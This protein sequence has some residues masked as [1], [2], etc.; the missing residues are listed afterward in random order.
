VHVHHQQQSHH[1]LNAEP[2]AT[3]AALATRHGIC[4]F[5]SIMNQPQWFTSAHAGAWERAKEALRRDWNQT[6]HDLRVGGHE[7]NQALDDTVSQV[8]GRETI[9]P[10]DA[11]NPP[12][13]IGRWED[14]EVAIGFGYACRTHY[15]ADFPEWNAALE[16]LLEADWRG[17]EPWTS[18]KLYV[19]HGYEIPR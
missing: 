19:R 11:P 14:A 12:R 7:L 8:R 6:K 5:L 13:V 18:V 9:P 15:G 1:S 2:T 16:R 10:I 17:D 3:S 4:T